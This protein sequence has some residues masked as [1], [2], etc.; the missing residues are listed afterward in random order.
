MPRTEKSRTLV[1]WFP[2]WPVRARAL[3]EDIPTDSPIAL[4]ERGLVFACS[5]SARA[6]GV[7]RGLRLREAQ[8]TC[9]DLLTFEYDSALDH[10]S[11]EPVMNAIEELMPGVQM[12]RPGTCALDARGPSRY[13]GGEN[14]VAQVLLNTLAS[15]EVTRLGED[16]E[17]G[18]AAS[19][20]TAANGGVAVTTDG[21]TAAVGAF[22]A[23]IAIADGRFAAERAVRMPGR[24]SIRIVAPS[25]S[26]QFLAPQPIELIGDQALATLLRRLGLTTLGAFA[27]LDFRDVRARF[28][29]TGVYAHSLAS[30]GDLRRVT[31]RLPPQLRDIE[32]SFEPPL[33]LVDQITFAFRTAAERFVDEL[34]RS[35]LVCT[36]IRVELHTDNGLM[37]E[38]GWGHPRWFSA[39]D[40]LDRIRWQVQ[41][42]MGTGNGALKS[43]ITKVRVLP[44]GLDTI[45]NYETGLW[46]S[47]P[48]DRVHHGLSR[49]QSLLGHGGVVTAVIGGGRGVAERQILTP[50]GDPVEGTAAASRVRRGAAGSRAADGAATVAGGS[51]TTAGR[52]TFKPWP[53]SVPLPAPSSVFERPSRVTVLGVSGEAVEVDERGAL[54]GVPSR[55]A[56]G[57]GGADGAGR[58]G[59]TSAGT[60][61]S[62]VGMTRA[63]VPQAI[64][65][66][67]GPWPVHER[68]WDQEQA[69][70]FHR[71]Q[72]VD[73]DGTAWLL[74]LHDKTWWAEAR[75]D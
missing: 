60:A 23:R 65:A 9:P 26:P 64:T 73:A 18:A 1:V 3:I 30:G 74:A 32:V 36:S 42:R 45:G 13:Y 55:F 24:Q 6:E 8:A 37:H 43:P 20:E 10:R 44:E 72:V 46:G 40:V 67:A 54:T 47:T 34:T 15:L 52:E 12:L 66:W 4:I 21:G 48:D 69:R 33:E 14:Q 75:Y 50:W 7:R 38:R 63:P 2:D 19:G 49:V 25:T 70:S 17:A 61:P 58:A 29:E 39:N 31:P 57:A 41:G 16:G 35:L 62:T 22:A 27:A 5:S 53:G 51:R 56:P 28:G 59:N 11:F 71:F 68:W